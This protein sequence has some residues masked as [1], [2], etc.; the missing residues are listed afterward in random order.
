M[1]QRRDRVEYKI[2]QK[3]RLT[4]ESSYLN[5]NSGYLKEKLVEVNRW[6]LSSYT[7]YLSPVNFTQMKF[8][9]AKKSIA[10]PR[11][12]FRRGRSMESVRLFRPIFSN[13]IK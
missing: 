2:T 7:N 4:I 8:Y 1:R 13:Y 9:C 12:Y 3:I 6:N 11:L 5:L 10:I